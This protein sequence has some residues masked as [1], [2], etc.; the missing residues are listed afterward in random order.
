[1]Q[2][3]ACLLRVSFS[4]P[5]I[6]RR[7]NSI[8]FTFRMKA[9]V[10]DLRK[11]M[12]LQVHAARCPCGQMQRPELIV[13]TLQGCW[14]RTSGRLW[15][16]SDC[17]VRNHKR[18]KSRRQKVKK[19]K[20]HK[21]PSLVLKFLFFVYPTCVVEGKVL[22]PSNGVPSSEIFQPLHTLRIS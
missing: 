14:A 4:H 2:C 16:L 13:S 22:W 17:A 11:V 18:L 5:S 1:M 6:C 9:N 7:G 20:E 19:Q 8:P 12:E 15:N 21:V 10:N 3:C